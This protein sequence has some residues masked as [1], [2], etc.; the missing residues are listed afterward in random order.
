MDYKLCYIGMNNNYRNIMSKYLTCTLYRY[1]LHLEIVTDSGFY[2]NSEWNKCLI[3]S[4]MY[5]LLQT[6]WNLRFSIRQTITCCFTQTVLVLFETEEKSTALD[7]TGN[8]YHY[9]HATNIESGKLNMKILQ[10][11][12]YYYQLYW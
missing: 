2:T 6:R 9:Y 5:P 3:A 1:H 10:N 8:E 11:Y 4:I 12:C 7:Q